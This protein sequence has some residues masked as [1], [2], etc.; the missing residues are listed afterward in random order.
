[1]LEDNGLR[2]VIIEDNPPMDGIKFGIP[3]VREEE[4]DNVARLIENMGRLGVKIWVYNWMAGIGWARTHTHIPVG[5][6]CM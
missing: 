1:M 5:M 4:L 3:R 6:V 2:L